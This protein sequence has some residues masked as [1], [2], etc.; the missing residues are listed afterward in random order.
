MSQGDT[1][2]RLGQ[3]EHGST[4]YG[5]GH[6][7]V[8]WTQGC[9]LACRGCWN[10]D[11]WPAR[12]GF[13]LDVGVLVERALAAGDQGLTLL[14]GE[15]LQ[16]AEATLTLIQ[17]AQ[18]QGL[19]VFLYTGYERHELSGPAL[20]C[21]DAADIVVAGRYI[22]EE[23]DTTLRWRGS[24]NQTVLFNGDRYEQEAGGFEE[25]TDVEITMDEEGRLTVLG[26]PDGEVLQALID[27][28]LTADE[29]GRTGPSSPPPSV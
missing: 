13:T 27:L 23:R 5:P 3:L 18:G 22:E 26:Y 7:T 19:S 8:V 9:T 11:L 1:L 2:L 20:A 16:Q 17:T 25:G 6:R 24:R 4:I 12:G 28:E 21:L 29:R 10:A 14:G 15:P